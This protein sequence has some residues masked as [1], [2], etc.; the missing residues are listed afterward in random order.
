MKKINNI[1]F[2]IYYRLF[3]LPNIVIVIVSNGKD[4]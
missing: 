2:Y 1:L 3:V 4:K